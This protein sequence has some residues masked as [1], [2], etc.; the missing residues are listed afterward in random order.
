[1]NLYMYLPVIVP[2]NPQRLAVVNW[3]ST[4]PRK[5]GTAFLWSLRPPNLR[6]A[7]FAS[8]LMSIENHNRFKDHVPPITYPAG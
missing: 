1:M 4:S 2:A 5:K 3:P 7:H 6:I 8:Q